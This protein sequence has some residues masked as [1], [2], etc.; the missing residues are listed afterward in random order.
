[1]G[2]N[3][4]PYFNNSGY[5]DPTAYE[6]IRAV[7]REQNM[8]LDGKVTMLYRVLHFIIS[9]AGFEVVD[10]I[11]VTVKTADEKLAQIVEAN[12]DAIVVSSLYGQGCCRRCRSFRGD[13]E[14][15]GAETG[16]CLFWKDYRTYGEICEYWKKRG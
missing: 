4:N 1:M 3:N 8:S 5:P 16:I 15:P 11:H 7:S 2:R 9:E 10:R 14:I 13:Y 12:A 6:A